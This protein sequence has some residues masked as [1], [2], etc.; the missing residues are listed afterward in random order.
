MLMRRPWVVVR[1]PENP[2][3]PCWTDLFDSQNAFDSAHERLKKWLT[4]MAL[5][6]EDLHEKDIDTQIR[7]TGISLF[8]YLS[9]F[10]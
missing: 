2:I 5:K 1:S 7:F 3:H 8:V 10:D 6:I 9:N 4:D